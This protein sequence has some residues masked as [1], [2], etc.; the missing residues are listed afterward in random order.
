MA[1]PFKAE[2]LDCS[3]LAIDQCFKL[4]IGSLY[5]FIKRF[6]SETTLFREE[7]REENS[8]LMLTG[9]KKSRQLVSL[10]EDILL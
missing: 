10:L 2:K 9:V 6:A 5:L 4:R 3:C 8:R 7:F 1:V